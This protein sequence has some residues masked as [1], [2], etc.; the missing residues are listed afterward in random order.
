METTKLK[1]KSFF[2]TAKDQFRYKNALAAPVIEKVVVNVGTGRKAKVAKD[3]N[4][5]VAD[6]LLKITGQKPKLNSA[7]K[8][9]ASFKLREGDPVGLAVTLRGEKANSFVDKLIHIALPRTRDFRGLSR[10]SVDQIG[11]LTIGIKEHTIFPA[12]ADEDLHNV[13]GMSVTIVTSAKNKAEA[14]AF[15]EHLGIPF[16]KAK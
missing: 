2:T 4:E 10:T 8:S 5:H 7:K 14:L 15:F 16:V 9:I 6:R 11:N 12:T 13:F 1:V 3:W